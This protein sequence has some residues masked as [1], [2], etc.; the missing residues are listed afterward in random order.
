MW[1]REYSL[2]MMWSPFLLLHHTRLYCNI[3]ARNVQPIQW[4]KPTNFVNLTK[5]SIFLSKVIFCTY[6]LKVIFSLESCFNWIKEKA[7]GLIWIQNIRTLKVLSIFVIW[8]S[9]RFVHNNLRDVNHLKIYVYFKR[10]INR[11]IWSN[12]LCGQQY[13]VN[14][15]RSSQITLCSWN[16]TLR[17]L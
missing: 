4:K 8:K 16:K 2:Q 11:C 15:S 7:S 6:P 5:T 1:S 3:M 17:V 14:C 10:Y 13:Y 9:F 12:W